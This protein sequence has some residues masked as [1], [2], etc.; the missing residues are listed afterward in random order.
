MASPS[1]VE[2]EG[3]IKAEAAPPRAWKAWARLALASLAL[4]LVAGVV[5]LPASSEQRP[6][7]RAAALQ[8]KF[9]VPPDATAPHI[10]APASSH[11]M[12]LGEEGCSHS[13]SDCVE[14]DELLD[15]DQREAI[16][17][18]RLEEQNGTTF[19]AYARSLRYNP[20]NGVI[21]LWPGGVVKYAWE[22]GI[23]PAARKAIE[24]GM[25]QLEAK[26]CVK[27][28][29]ST[30]GKGV[31]LFK[32]S[33]EGCNAHIGWN[34]HHQHHLNL[35][36]PGCAHVGIAIHELGHT[37]GL[38][39]E[40]ARP[41]A[42]QY[43]Q[44]NLNNADEWWKQ[45]LK[46]YHNAGDMSAGL[47]YDMGS[48]M[49]YGAWA[50][51]K[52]HDNRDATKTI[53]VKKVDVFGNC[54]VGQRKYLSQGDI[55]TTNRWYGCP[56]HFCADLNTHCKSWQRQG[57]CKNKYKEWMAQNCP[58]TCGKCECKD[59]DKHEK[60][61]PG[62][63][64]AGY[65]LRGEKGTA[66]NKQFM[67]ENCPKSCGNCLMED[68]SLCKDKTIWN[69]PNGCSKHKTGMHEGKPWCKNSW[70]ASQCPQSCN[71]CPHQPF[72]W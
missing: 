45:W 14:G 57:N 69:D 43:I 41:E 71:L 72:C 44:F 65:C 24:E 38:R 32:S 54:Q 6:Q 61:C 56:N 9:K 46:T 49:H 62:W 5:L 53:T 60:D 31:V 63:A 18:R 1:D 27:F 29:E 17:A 37:I 20:H 23:N 21:K 11:M 15:P 47:P 2:V 48:I 19:Q 8:E 35:Q 10:Q 7:L 33:G 50:G 52:R 12:G 22:R 40:H 51:A 26:T 16:E 13:D 4:A 58:H 68:A 66:H 30:A 70:F 36:P 3:L 28:Q 42:L 67:I 55:L 34:P 64:K 25:L 39:H 59:N